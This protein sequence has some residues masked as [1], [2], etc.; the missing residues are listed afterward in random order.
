MRQMENSVRP[1]LP[2]LYLEVDGARL[3]YRDEGHG[4]A[5][6][7]I[8]GWML[9]LDMWEAQAAALSAAYRVIRL[10]RRGFGLSSGLPSLARDVDDLAAL[11]RHLKL[12]HV[13]ILG[14]SQGARVALQFAI[15]SPESV[16][17]LI[18]DGP[19]RLDAAHRADDPAELPYQHYR[20]LAQS[21]GVAAFR[22]EWAVHPLVSL[23]TRDPCTRALLARMIER[24][25]GRDLTDAQSGTDAPSGPAFPATRQMIESI[26]APVLLIGG[27]LDLDSRK[28]FADELMSQFVHVERAQIP[29]A[30]HLC[31]LDDPAAYTFALRQF[32]DRRT[33][34]SNHP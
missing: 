18:L 27:A 32:L 12:R 8:H 33:P 30:G 6:I 17:C 13:A 16:A 24:S 15:R 2:D 21:Q 31:S 23:R 9:D 25:P 14:M 29:D 11:C 20:A 3:R 28:R 22:R 4:P 5:L 7:L 19:P 26:R 10:D 1:R 34:A